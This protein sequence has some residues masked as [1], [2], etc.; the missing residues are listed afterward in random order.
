RAA[1]APRGA[2]RLSPL[3]ERSG[4]DRSR[5]GRSPTRP[6]SYGAWLTS[7]A[8]RAASRRCGGVARRAVPALASVTTELPLSLTNAEAR[9][10]L[11]REWIDLVVVAGVVAC[12]LLRQV[13]AQVAPADGEEAIGFLVTISK[14]SGLL[15]PV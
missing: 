15:E 10:G 2:G 9:T 12:V 3:R 4:E 5:R 1:Q 6:G 11:H 7:R 13:A 14:G 8:A